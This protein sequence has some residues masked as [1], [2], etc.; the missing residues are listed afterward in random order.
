MKNNCRL[1]GIC[2]AGVYAKTKD[3]S[4]TTYDTRLERYFCKLEEGGFVVDK[5]LVLQTNP[6]K[7]FEDIFRGPI[8]DVSKPD[9]FA[10]GNTSL[11]YCGLNVYIDRQRKLGA[12]IG[13]RK[14]NQ[15]IWQGGFAPSLI[16]EFD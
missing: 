2:D 10:E 8:L 14:G 16:E 12:K 7:V 11:S 5:R 4:I 1:I 9:D 15:I 6:S 13:V 3:S